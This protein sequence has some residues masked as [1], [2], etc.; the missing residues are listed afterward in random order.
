[1]TSAAKQKIAFAALGGITVLVTLPVLLIVGVIVR[2]GVG[3]ISWQFLTTAP[4]H[5][6]REGGIFPAIV[7]TFFLVIIMSIVGVPVGAI[8]AMSLTD[9]LFLDR[10]RVPTRWGLLRR[11]AMRQ[12]T[13][14]MMQRFDIRAAG[15]DVAF[16]SLSGGNQQ[17]AV[18]ARELTAPKLKVLLAAQPTRG[19][20]VGAVEAV[21]G[22]IRAACERGVAVVL[23]SSELDE[24]LAVADRELVLYRGRVVGACP[25][26][27]GQRDRIGG[28]MAGQAA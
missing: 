23:V 18:L 25:A 26:E 8:T 13:L 14:A 1:M 17:K 3:A 7:G 2:Y 5:G 15:P 16:G 20:D 6:M 10:A 27:P 4:S 19:L 22:L 11:A 24:I 12:P 9:N 21:Y 28:L